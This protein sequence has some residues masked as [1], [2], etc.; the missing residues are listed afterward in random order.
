[1]LL[2]K[3]QST[4]D[5]KRL[6]EEQIPVLAGEIRQFLL[7]HISKTGGHL[8]ANLGVVELTILLHQV[9]NVEYDHIVWDVGHQSC[10]HKLLTGRRDQ[11][12]SLRQTGG[13]S[14]FPKT[15][16]DETDSFNTGH[17]STSISAAVGFA[18]SAK[19]R[20]E[21]RCGVA[22][23]GDGALTGGMA[24]EALNHA[25]SM[26]IP[27]VVVLNDNGMSISK[28]VGGLSRN[29]KRIRNNPKY[30]QLKEDVRSILDHIPLVGP[31]MERQM[32]RGKRA[33][34]RVLTQG[35][36]FEDLGLT[37]LGPVDG[38]NLR[39]LRAVLRQAK[40]MNRPVLVHVHTKKG[41]GYAPAEKNPDQ[42]HGVAG[43]DL[44]TG[45][46]F[47][48]SGE[49][50]SD[51]FGRQLCQLAEEDPRVVAITAAMPEGTGLSQF[52]KKF[53]RRFFDVGI[54]E[55]H[56]VTFAA[57][58]AKAGEIPCFAVYS[59]FLQRGYDQLLH[60]ISLQKLHGVFCLDRSGPVGQDGETH[61]GVFDIS[62]LSHL[63]GFTVLSPSDGETFDRMLRYAVLDCQGPVAIRYPRG[64]VPKTMLGPAAENQQ[65]MNRLRRAGKDLLFLAVGT[66][67][68]DAMEAAEL[69]E[70]EGISAG[71]LEMGM[72]KPLNENELKDH[73]D[74]FS[75][76]ISLEDNVITGGFGEQLSAILGRKVQI[77][78]YP[79]EPIG[80]G[81]VQEIKEKYGL[82]PKQIAKAVAQMMRNE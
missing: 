64:T 41:K 28:N 74:G 67:V 75:T 25:G 18:V 38:Y 82:L 39:D 58:L 35:K 49:S 46:L 19:L 36:I 3:I 1:M 62:Y 71:V 52:Q 24:F 65:G 21:K 69:L 54:A 57:G 32:T 31:A 30:F 76:I 77:F 70:Q 60:D 72:I 20:G 17:S 6:S 14:G 12:D 29:F 80:Q 2:E 79:D 78:A 61:Q 8:A 47:A 53:P 51:R 44:Q 34:K 40:T 42:F 23:I 68:W 48:G 7:Q 59:S 26:N 9:F 16:E 27:L 63:P 81:T 45:D 11:F 50:W 5:V 73:C 13:I 37:Y 43:F 10:V 22:V 15:Q 55:Q 4:K 56:A 33:L 66:T